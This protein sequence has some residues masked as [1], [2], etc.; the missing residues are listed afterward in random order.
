MGLL[1]HKQLVIVRGVPKIQGDIYSGEQDLI[2]FDLMD[3]AGGVSLIEWSPNIPSLKSGGVWADS[4]ISD[5]R[6]LT[7]GFN[8]NVVEDIT[9]QFSFNDPQLYAARMAGLNRLIQGARQFWDT[10]GQNE[11]VY[12]QWWANC[13]PGPQYALIYNIDTDI[14]IDDSPAAMARVTLSIEREFGWRGLPPGANP[15]LWALY[16][17]GTPPALPVPIANNPGNNVNLFT[18]TN[19]LAT[20][21]VDN[22]TEINS[23]GV[24][25]S[26]NYF[27]IPAASI[28]GD[29]PALAFVGLSVGGSSVDEN[30]IFVSRWSKRTTML[31][32]EP[33]GS[34]T[35]WGVWH[36]LNLANGTAGTDTTF[37]ADTGAPIQAAAA[38]GRRS[39][40]TFTTA[41]M[42]DRVT[43]TTPIKPLFRGRFA[44]FLRAR[45]S[46]AATVQIQL[47]LNGITTDFKTL[48]DLGTGGTGNTTEW[49]VVYMGTLSLPA[50]A[51]RSD[52]VTAGWG[53]NNSQASAGF[54]IIVQAA[55]STGS[56][57][58]YMSD[59]IFMPID[60]DESL[61]VLN[62]GSATGDFGVYNGAIDNTGYL[63][64][65]G[66]D[67][68]GAIVG[69]TGIQD[70]APAAAQLS[71][72]LTLEPNVLNRLILFTYISSTN[73]SRIDRTITAHVNIVP[74]WANIR[75]V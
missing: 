50:D 70:I 23:S 25:T 9:V 18:S 11:P 15:K 10:F 19:N 38:A 31:F 53:V 6:I 3:N 74:R 62:D 64:R 14:E 22:R 54:S 60:E 16:R 7:A 2:T 61:L 35:Q 21:T 69:T 71:G 73:R 12:L 52:I 68:I 29:L 26:D 4:P 17:A 33:P 13:A 67:E 20:G 48:S 65:G 57:E 55:R 58:L 37:V 1:D 43:I 47:K 5:G 42:Q 66:I 8:T 34:Q 63:A 41:T 72:A 51:S 39:R 44:I 75:D 46:A 45:V 56:G 27:D 59:L 24:L 40:T 36:Q 32:R 30:A 49:A 28:P